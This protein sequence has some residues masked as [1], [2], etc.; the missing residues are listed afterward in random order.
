[1]NQKAVAVQPPPKDFYL[2]FNLDVNPN[3]AALLLAACAKVTSMGVE[4]I[5][6]LLNSPG[7]HVASGIGVY[8]TLRALPSKVHTYNI[9]SVDS[10]TNVIFQAGETRTAAEDATFLFH[11]VAT[12]IHAQARFDEAQLSEILDSIEKDNSRIVDILARH[13]SI[14]VE[15]GREF[16]RK[17]KTLRAEEALKHG[18][19]E[20]IG[21][22]NVP[23]GAPIEQLVLR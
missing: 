10:I 13:T 23:P 9:G 7:G 15:Q 12:T 8:N 17:G 20:K 1:M 21:P 18:V 14:D 19:I 5:H 2:S 3:S 11:G 22:V 16:I 6:L 4:N